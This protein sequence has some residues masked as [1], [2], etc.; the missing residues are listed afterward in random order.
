[1]EEGKESDPVK[2]AETLNAERKKLTEA[3]MSGTRKQVKT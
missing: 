1:V 3:I 2:D